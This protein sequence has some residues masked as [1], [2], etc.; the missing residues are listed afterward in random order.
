[1]G[2]VGKV[3]Y[4]GRAA[5]T[6]AVC[7][8][9]AVCLCVLVLYAPAAFAFRT[10]TDS[11]DLAGAG[12]VAWRESEVGFSLCR[13]DLPPDVT[14][15]EVEAALRAALAT[16]SAPEC[17]HIR[18]FFVGWV[19]ERPL[20]QDGQNSVAWVRDWKERSFPASAPGNTDVQYQGLEGAWRI[21]EA[22]I[23]LDAQ[24]FKWSVHGQAS[25]KDVEA[26][27]T[28]EL[29]H[30]LGLLHPCETDGSDGAPVCNGLAAEAEATMY[31]LYS[32]EQA[33]LAPD[34]VEGVCYLY[35]DAT[36]ACHGCGRLE[37]CVGTECHARCGATVCELGQVCGSWGCVPEGACTAR[38]C[39]ERSCASDEMCGPL[40]RCVGGVCRGGAAAWGDRCTGSPDCTSG[41][42]VAD[43]CQPPCHTDA[44]C[45]PNGACRPSVDTPARGCE[46][47]GAYAAGMVCRVG[48]DCRS[49]LC[50]FTERGAACTTACTSSEACSTGWACELVEGRQVCVPETISASGG[51]RVGGP[52]GLGAG[53]ELVGMAFPLTIATWLRRRRSRRKT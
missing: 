17:S 38:D 10:A 12:R 9:F 18:P 47:S 32:L 14:E 21:A 41:A 34:D 40:A 50:I 48:E 20:P 3:R 23:Y 33:S 29:G 15:E 2:L 35:P 22:D 46:E 4:S 16:W 6:S 36:D 45:G 8:L 39:R 49:G 44:E 26:V 31:P 51:C 42:C 19:S 30:A 13:E 43:V 37:V 1:M 7:G 27:L 28:H 25:R 24:D 5:H 53:L 11:P 52:G